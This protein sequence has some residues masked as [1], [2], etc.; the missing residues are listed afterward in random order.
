MGRN[1]VEK[2]LQAHSREDDRMHLCAFREAD[3][4]DTGGRAF[5]PHHVRVTQPI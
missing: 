1:I 5:E 2:V 4:R 3:R